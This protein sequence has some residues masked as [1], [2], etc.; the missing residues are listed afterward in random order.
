MAAAVDIGPKEVQLLC[1]ALKKATTSA[2]GVLGVS[3]GGKAI[4][5]AFA[6]KD[7]AGDPVHAGNVVREIAGIVGGGGGGRPD[8]AQAGGKDPSRLADAVAEG[9]RL[10]TAA[11]GG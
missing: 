10:M 7:L 3:A 4:L 9:G 6:T 1:D 2:C 5:A 11:L 8:F